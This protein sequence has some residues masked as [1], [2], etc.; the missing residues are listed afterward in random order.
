MVVKACLFTCMLW[1]RTT[2]MSCLP[3][4]RVLALPCGGTDSCSSA[5]G[6]PESL[7]SGLGS[8]AHKRAISKFCHV[9]DG[10]TC[11]H[12]YPVPTLPRG[13][14]GTYRSYCIP[15]HPHGGLETPIH[16]SASSQQCESVAWACLFPLL[17][18]PSAGTWK[19]EL[20]YL[21]ACCV[22]ATLWQHGC[23]CSYICQFQNCYVEV[24]PY[25]LLGLPSFPC[26]NV[27]PG[28]ACHLLAGFQCSHLASW[29]GLF[30]N[31]LC[32]RATK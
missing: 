11:P 22:K 3:M 27:V 5:V 28:H 1:H 29:T 18:C 2:H 14:L 12:A 21:R 9:V 26:H 13:C 25:L 19:P 6:I 20:T 30:S 4:Y 17:P 15:A 23:A 8:L 31:L 7:H 16:F 32:H 10:L 24:W